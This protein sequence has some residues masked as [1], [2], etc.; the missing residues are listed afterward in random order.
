[1]VIPTIIEKTH[2]GERHYD[3]FSRLLNERI[4]LL[5]GE[6]NDKIASLIIAQLLYLAAIDETKDIQLYI[7]SPGG[8]V[9]AGLAIY[10]T[11]RSI[12]C[13][14]S[15]ICVGLCASMG[16]FLLA[17]GKKGKRYTL[18]NSEIMIHQ[19]LG[20][21]QGPAKDVEIMTKR[22]LR[23]KDK[24]NQIM[25]NNTGQPFDRIEFDTDR[26]YFLT[27]KEALDYGIV[28]HI[29]KNKVNSD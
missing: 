9:T 23:L 3:I 2:E 29:I 4:V 28:D 8:S 10:D 5:T 25:A 6:I 12:S 27:A 13:D 1:M 24:L 26:D 14:V 18:E 15:T 20:G 7:N 16:A 19:P 22:L 21:G 17:G 11:M